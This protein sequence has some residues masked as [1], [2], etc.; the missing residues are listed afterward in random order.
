MYQ[1]NQLK[2][3]RN[4]IWDIKDPLKQRWAEIVQQMDT[5]INGV[6]PMHIFWNRR[7]LESKDPFAIEYRV[8]NFSPVTKQAFDRALA[9]IQ[10]V[11][12]E[13]N[14]E[15]KLPG[16][17]LNY[18][19]T[20]K[21][22]DA[23]VFCIMDLVRV[24]END[25]NA[26]AV[27]IP[28]IELIDEQ[29]VTVTGVNPIIVP[30]KDIDTIKKDYIKFI[31]GHIKIKDKE[32]PYYYI[33]DNGQYSLEYPQLV[34]DKVEM[35]V[36]PIILIDPQEKAFEYISNNVVYEGKYTLRTPYLYGSAA[37][38]DKFYANDTD[39]N[40]QETRNTYIK[41]IRAKE[42]CQEIGY[43]TDPKTLRHVDA[44]TGKDCP[45][46]KGLGYVKDDSPL[47][48]IFIDFDRIS[49]EGKTPPP[50][51]QYSEPPQAALTNSQARVDTYYERMCEALGL[52]K[53]NFTNQSGISKEFD[54]KQQLSLIYKILN[55]NIRVL[56]YVYRA[57]EQFLNL[58]GEITSDVYLVGEIGKSSIDELLE[59]LKQAKDNQSPP[60]VI[61]SLI[62]QI[63][64]KSLSQDVSDLIIDVAKKYDKLYIY[65]SDEI[66]NARAQLG[67]VIGV[68]EVTIHNTVIDVLKEYLETTNETDHDK[69]IAY[70]DEYY[71]AT[72]P[73]TPVSTGI[74]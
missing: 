62:D 9:G 45:H 51:I 19:L 18:E 23:Y 33:I 14:V 1:E 7:P 55:D 32:H 54:Y 36:F 13:A 15:V 29:S 44:S 34:N 68:R 74:L 11:C 49:N 73:A 69:I 39:L 37:W 65:G 60:H 6:C 72:V 17:L 30:S 31:G 43:V 70:L 71:N 59:K 47:S 27:V 58:G 41:E 25:P 8:N 5:H 66:V 4:P 61:M 63:Y 22:R 52:I 50:V 64:Q 16:V 26:V 40:I 28:L 57:S 10:E 35:Q 53:Q 12:N 46:C 21:D 67:N 56:K 20:I 42:K 24:R 38:G 48:T 2:T 3:W